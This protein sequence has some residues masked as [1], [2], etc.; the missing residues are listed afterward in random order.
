MSIKKSLDNY[1]CD[2]LINM[3]LD[4]H[5]HS[6]FDENIK[7]LNCELLQ[8]TANEYTG[9]GNFTNISIYIYEDLIRTRKKYLKNPNGDWKIFYDENNRIAMY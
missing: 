5:L 3:I 1:L 2:D 7:Y 8:K 4:F 6:I 9:K